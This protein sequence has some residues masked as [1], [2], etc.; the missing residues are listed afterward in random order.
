M[1]CMVAGCKR[2][3]YKETNMKK[4]IIGSLLGAGA[5]FG[6]SRLFACVGGG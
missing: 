5:G 2:M 6:I 4:I 1:Q 3:A